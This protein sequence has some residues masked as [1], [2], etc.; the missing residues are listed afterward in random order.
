MSEV[1]SDRD[2]IRPS[3][4]VLLIN[5]TFMD[6]EIML[7]YINSD[8]SLISIHKTLYLLLA[9]K[10][11]NSRCFYHLFPLK[12]THSADVA[13]VSEQVLAGLW[14][15]RHNGLTHVNHVHLPLVPQ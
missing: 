8:P 2:K 14:V 6:P 12:F 15:S 11:S 9:V 13:A 10:C 3:F 4:D 7:Y 1:T 5:V